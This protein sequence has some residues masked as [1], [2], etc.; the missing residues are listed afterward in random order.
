M[1][2]GAA[3]RWRRSIGCG[4]QRF[5]H[6]RCSDLSRGITLSANRRVLYLASFVAMFPNCIISMS[7]PTLRVVASSRSCST[8]SSGEPTITYPLST[9]PFMSRASDCIF[10]AEAALVEGPLGA[11][12]RGGDLDLALDAGALGRLRHIARRTGEPHIDV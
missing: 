8:T 12:P 4:H 7:W 3:A 6:S 10:C 1:N 2:A 9:M 11:L 5:S